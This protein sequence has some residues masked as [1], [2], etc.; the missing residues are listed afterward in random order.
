MK[1]ENMFG[2]KKKSTKVRREPVIVKGMGKKVVEDEEEAIPMRKKRKKQCMLVLGSRGA[3]KS[4]AI[5][6]CF[7]QNCRP[8]K[9]GNNFKSFWADESE[10]LLCAEVSGDVWEEKEDGM[11]LQEEL[12]AML[13][14]MGVRE[15]SA[16]AWCVIPAAGEADARKKERQAAFVQML[17]GEEAWDRLVV[18]CKASL[19][20]ERDAEDALKL[21]RSGKSCKTVGYRLMESS[22]GVDSEHEAARRLKEAVD[23]V[24]QERG[25]ML[26]G[27]DEDD[28]VEDLQLEVP[29]GMRRMTWVGGLPPIV[30]AKPY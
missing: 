15:V 20:P 30:Y 25:I 5:R 16:V 6:L 4:T 24:R 3:G 8:A 21:V 9:E 19:K 13:L 17:G 2:S 1:V 14:T 27:S 11:A 10:D 26:F 18:V 22:E 12:L 7:G 28:E 23:S 29:A